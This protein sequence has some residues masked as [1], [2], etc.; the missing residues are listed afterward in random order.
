MKIKRLKY[1]EHTELHR[2]INLRTKQ[3][4][5]RFSLLIL[6]SLFLDFVDELIVSIKYMLI[7]WTT[8]LQAHTSLLSSRSGWIRTGISTHV[9]LGHPKWTHRLTR[10]VTLILF[11]FFVKGVQMHRLKSWEWF[12]VLTPPGVQLVIESCQ[13]HWHNSSRISAF[14]PFPGP[15]LDWDTH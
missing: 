13:I 3:T 11:S 8:S 4:K 2:A 9:T 15:S 1:I 7:R 5:S 14:P 10:T 6:F 12:F